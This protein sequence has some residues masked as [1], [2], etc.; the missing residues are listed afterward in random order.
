MEPDSL[1]LLDFLFQRANATQGYWNFYIAVAT[2]FLGIVTVGKSEWLAPI[3]VR[4]MIS[5]LFIAFAISNYIPLEKTREQRHE[6]IQ[7]AALTDGYQQLENIFDASRPLLKPEL[8]G[9]HIFSDLL[10]L[11]AI[12]GI[13]A[14]RLR[15]EKSSPQRLE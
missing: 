6:I 1:K 14:A 2:V 12:W 7:A 11:V 10:I 5:I 3:K 8:L 13:P 4:T 15:F 9:F